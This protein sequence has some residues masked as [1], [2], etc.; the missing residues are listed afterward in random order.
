MDR[1][2]SNEDF[3]ETPTSIAKDIIYSDGTMDEKVK[4]I[5]DAIKNEKQKI[6]NDLHDCMKGVVSLDREFIE[7]WMGRFE[8]LRPTTAVS[9]SLLSDVDYWKQRCLLAEKC[10]EESP[11]D[12]DIT[13]D[14]I[15]ARN[16]YH[17]F[18]SGVGNDR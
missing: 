14:Q 2:N 10:L 9:G 17:K 16:A 11:C 8:Q 13:A 3:E 12:P 18:I 15:K 1:F 5:A 4:Q 6:L 7:E